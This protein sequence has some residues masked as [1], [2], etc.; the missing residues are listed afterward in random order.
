MWF[1]A[2]PTG[3]N[4]NY[5]ELPSSLPKKDSQKPEEE[6]DKLQGIGK[7][8]SLLVNLLGEESKG[9]TDSFW[10]NSGGDK[11]RV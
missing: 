2:P 11:V 1:L 7:A 9:H 4:R 6:K 8:K 10:H 5:K 3:T